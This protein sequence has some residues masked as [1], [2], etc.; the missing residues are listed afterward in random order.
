MFLHTYKQALKK[1]EEFFVSWEESFRKLEKVYSSFTTFESLVTIAKVYGLNP[2]EAAGFSEVFTE[3]L[4]MVLETF[5][6]KHGEHFPNLSKEEFVN[7]ILASGEV[8]IMS[9]PKA[10]SDAITLIT[11]L[12]VDGIVSDIYATTKLKRLITELKGQS[13]P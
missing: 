3:L 8:D 9:I 4:K 10:V 5:Y 7:T 12:D 2:P 6:E 1:G 11:A 13:A